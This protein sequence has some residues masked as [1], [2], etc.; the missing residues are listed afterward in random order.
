MAKADFVTGLVLIALGIGAFVESWRMPRLENLGV[1]PYTVPGI[2][3]GI[4]AV[5]ILLLGAILA[6]RATAAGG[7]RL[8]LTREAAAGLARNPAARRFLLAIALC[9]GYAAGLIG[10]VPFWAATFVFVLLFII[11]FEW[12][13]GTESARRLRGIAIALIE[14]VLVATVVTGVFQYVFLVRLP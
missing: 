2:V 10:A 13:S 9:C 14:A 4:L 7:W 12:Q 6:I 3:P 1:N 11:V 5:M 8:S